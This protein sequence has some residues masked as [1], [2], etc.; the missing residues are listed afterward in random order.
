MSHEIP[1]NIPKENDYA[2]ADNIHSYHIIMII[3]LIYCFGPESMMRS[4]ARASNPIPIPLR[5]EGGNIIF[6]SHYMYKLLSP[7]KNNYF[8]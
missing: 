5:P 4:Q 7:L 2:E 8:H 1:P 3:G 6:L